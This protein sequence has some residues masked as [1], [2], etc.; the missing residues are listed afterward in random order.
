MIYFCWCNQAP[1]SDMPHD[2]IIAEIYLLFVAPVRGFSFISEKICSD[3][4]VTHTSWEYSG[5]FHLH[6]KF[7]CSIK[8]SLNTPAPPI[9]QYTPWLNGSGFPECLPGNQ[10]KSHDPCYLKVVYSLTILRVIELILWPYKH[11]QG[12]FVNTV[13][14]ICFRRGM[15]KK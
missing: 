2:K 14:R 1:W 7:K 6:H 15:F 10:P 4:L 11:Y 9:S 5:P 13:L 8:Q 12:V 3:S